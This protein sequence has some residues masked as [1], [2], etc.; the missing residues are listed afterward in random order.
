MLQGETRSPVQGLGQ[1]HAR[2]HYVLRHGAQNTWGQP[3]TIFPSA[4]SGTQ[5]GDSPGFRCS[6]L[7][8]Q[9]K[10]TAQQARRS[11][12]KKWLFP[13][14]LFPPSLLLTGLNEAGNLKCTNTQHFLFSEQMKLLSASKLVQTAVSH[15]QFHRTSPSSSATKRT[16]TLTFS[17]NDVPKAWKK[18][19]KLTQLVEF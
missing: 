5:D 9:N 15:H 4:H 10:L 16:M 2:H 1:F 6:S 13:A 11:K 3:G 17:S 19:P 14:P 7:P 8:F 12:G 18:T